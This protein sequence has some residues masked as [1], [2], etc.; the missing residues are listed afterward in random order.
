MLFS[1]ASKILESS[2]VSSV[3]PSSVLLPNTIPTTR[4]RRMLPSKTP[5]V[6]IVDVVRRELNLQVQSYEKMKSLL[7]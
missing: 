1:S 6:D 7:N 5:T 2:I 4:I 3:P